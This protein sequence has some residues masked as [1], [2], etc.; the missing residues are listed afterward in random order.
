MEVD[1]PTL[2][3]GPAF[4]AQL[5]V[6]STQWR[7]GTSTKNYYLPTSPEISIKKLLAYGLENVFEVRSCFRNDE[8][9]PCHE[10]EFTML[11]W[12]RRGDEVGLLVEDVRNLFASLKVHGW[13]AKDLMPL[14]EVRV[15][16]LFQKHLNCSLTPQ[17]SQ[18]ELVELARS[19][20]LNPQGTESR[21]ELFNWIFVDKIEP[22][23][24]PEQPTIIHSYPAWIPTLAKIDEYGWAQRFELYCGGFELANAF[25]ELLDYNEHEQR[26]LKIAQI[27]REQ[28]LLPLGRDEEFFT[29]I[30]KGIPPTVGIAMG[31]ERLFMVVQD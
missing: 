19:L 28:N 22:Q 12:Y 14:A 11:E 29:A 9:G 3:Q 1:T 24:N 16:D 15:A 25:N 4:E 23:L 10:P 17:T 13:L 18:Q 20:A 8:L 7:Y 5:E 27:R 31:L 30:K 6:F 2:V 21:S 26:W